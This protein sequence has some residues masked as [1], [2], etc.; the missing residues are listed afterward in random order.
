MEYSYKQ[1]EAALV[2][3]YRSA[4]AFPDQEWE[5]DPEVRAFAEGAIRGRLK[6]MQK[7]GIAPSRPGTGRRISYRI[8]DIMLWAFCLELAECGLDPKKIQLF[9]KR[10]WP[11]AWGSI[12]TDA[13]DDADTLLS[14][15]PAFLSSWSVS[16]DSFITSW[17]EAEVHHVGE[18]DIWDNWRGR[19]GAPHPHSSMRTE[20]P[21]G[22]LRRVISVNLSALYR[23]VRA[24]LEAVT[25]P[26]PA[27]S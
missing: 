2:R 5:C 23:T 25:K 26:P 11:M 7:M 19:H 27:G 13:T 3:M 21:K 17:N 22:A 4:F 24:A 9:I 1:V 12:D 14:F 6:N 10:Y 20:D 16:G 18:F 15:R 8:E